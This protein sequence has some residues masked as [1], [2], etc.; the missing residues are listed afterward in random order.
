MIKLENEQ[1]IIEVNEAGAELNKLYS[2]KYNLDFLWCGDSK[3]WGRKSPVLFPIVGR[4]KDNE[5]YIENE[6]FK[7]GQ[8]GFARDS[9][10]KLIDT[11]NS[12][13]TFSLASK[14]SSME[15]FPFSYR[16]NITYEL[17]DNNLAVTWNVINTDD[18]PIYFS[19][20]AHPAFNVPFFKEDKLEDYYLTYKTKE[21]INHYIFEPP[22]IKESKVLENLPEATL[23]PTLFKND[24]LV[25][26]GVDNVT[27]NSKKSTAAISLSFKDFPFVGIW[28]PYYKKTDSIAPFLCIEPWYGIA[29]FVNGNKKYKDKLGINKLEI[30]GDFSAT[31][32]ISLL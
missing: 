20:G 8:H 12:S 26:S 16:L 13:V 4:L 1:I 19:I 23:K 3:Y 28:S 5:T 31:Y 27:I 25:Y 29:D 17:T 10:F 32:T 30:G 11:T 18:K 2:K 7:M 9:I 6:I 21:K 22:Y 15:N 24:A 14:E